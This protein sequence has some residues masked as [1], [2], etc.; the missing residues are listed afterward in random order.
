MHKK[1]I[2]AI[3]MAAIITNLSAT[4]IEVL[5]DEVKN[6]KDSSVKVEYTNEVNQAVISKFDLYNDDKLNAYNEVFKM[7][8]SNI[9][10]ITNNGG[11]YASSTIDKAIDENLNTHWETGK[12]NSSE[13]TN[14]VVF[15]FNEIANLNR[16]VYAARKDIS[17]GKGFAQEFEIYASLTEEGDDF[18]LV[19]TGEYTGSTKDLVEIKFDST[20]FKRLKFKFKK[21]S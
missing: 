13:F 17:S 15:T 8:N 10:S 4:T 20:D 12:P 9:K 6:A 18:R 19:S 21:A 5:A 16:I 7:D 3:T 2:A 14:E 11:K 1:K